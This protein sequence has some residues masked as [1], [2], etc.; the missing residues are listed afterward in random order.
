MPGRGVAI[1]LSP[2]I[3]PSIRI[4]TVHELGPGSVGLRPSNLFCVDSVVCG[5]GGGGL[6]VEGG[7]P[8][9]QRCP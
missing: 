3:S 7:G 4:S 9:A 8:S 6:W 5:G 2:H 1:S